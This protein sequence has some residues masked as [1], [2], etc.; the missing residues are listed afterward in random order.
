MSVFVHAFCKKLNPQN[1]CLSAWEAGPT[2]VSAPPSR[3]PVIPH[4]PA[5]IPNSIA[6]HS[7]RVAGFSRPIYLSPST[8]WN[9]WNGYS[10]FSAHSA[11]FS[12]SSAVKS[13]VAQFTRLEDPDLPTS[14]K[15]SPAALLREISRVYDTSTFMGC[16][17][18]SAYQ[19][20][21]S[22]PTC[23]STEA[24]SFGGRRQGVPQ[25]P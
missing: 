7:A 8:Q 2:P 5:P 17:R 16:R 21:G 20:L 1:Q 4:S 22:H 23:P 12:A 10:V 15:L 11:E 13:F 19:C 25:P 18:R 14:S 24:F 6:R 9:N 3:A